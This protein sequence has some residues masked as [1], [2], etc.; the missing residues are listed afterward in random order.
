MVL[1]ISLTGGSRRGCPRPSLGDTQCVLGFT[2]GCECRA[3]PCHTL[4]LRLQSTPVSSCP[5][6][7]ERRAVSSVKP[8]PL[9][10]LTQS[11]R[12]G[13]SSEPSTGPECPQGPRSTLRHPPRPSSWGKR[14]QWETGSHGY[15]VAEVGFQLG[16]LCLPPTPGSPGGCCDFSREPWASPASPSPAWTRERGEPGAF[17][18][19]LP[20][21]EESV[22]RRAAFHVRAGCVHGGG[23]G[24]CSCADTCTPVQERPFCHCGELRGRRAKG[25][26]SLPLP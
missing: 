10:L 12:W 9:R 15:L 14:A 6:S 18:P 4:L 7:C 25:S 23:E 5:R 24:G 17:S 13:H 16:S 20:A 21:S 3:A 26:G 2:G 8:S 22:C 11:P 1:C 19:H